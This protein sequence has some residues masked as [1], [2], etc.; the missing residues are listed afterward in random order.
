MTGKEEK[1]FRFT[2][3]VRNLV[4]KNWDPIG[5]DDIPEA[6]DEYDAYIPVICQLLLN[7]ASRKDLF[8]YLWELETGHM[9]LTGNKDH[10]LSFV[11]KLFSLN[12]N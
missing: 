12:Q 3:E 9:G 5:V 4:M 7:N 6:Q 2:L 8:D 1:N 10:T 11:E